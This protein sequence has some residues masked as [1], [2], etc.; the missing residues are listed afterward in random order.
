MASLLST[1]NQELAEVVTDVHGSVVQVRDI[2]PHGGVRGAG[3][4]TIWHKDG[5]IVTNAHVVARGRGDGNYQI[6]LADGRTLPARVI[7]RDDERDLA[8]LAVDGKDLP[9]IPVGSAK[10]LHPGEWVF[11]V[12]HPWG[13]RNV[14][15]GGVV[16][17]RGDRIPELPIG[18]RNDWVVVDLQLR[19]GN[20]GGPL[21]DTHGRMIGV[22][23]IMTG[24]GV[25]MAVSVDA[26]KDFLRQ[27]IGDR[28]TES[29][30]PT[31]VV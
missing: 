11:A 23:T 25:G 12:G 3:A 7:A 2:A 27:T 17:G 31:E 6:A 30:T 24:P 29:V 20:S 15:T 28:V 22:N 13:I 9:V 19:P 4:G 16:I 5:L 18:Y 1:L 10:R 8:A 14:T 26:V 21:V